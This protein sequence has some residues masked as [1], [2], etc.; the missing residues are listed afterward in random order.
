M[1]INFD[2]LRCNCGS[3]GC[4]EEYAS[5]K[6][7]NRR[8]KI[9]ATELDRLAKKGNKAAKEIWQDFGRNLGIGIANLVNILDPEIIVIGGG[10]SQ[11]GEF[12]LKPA[13]Q[14]AR[15]RIL[16]HLSRKNVKIKKSKL[17]DFA[18]AIGAGMILWT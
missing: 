3:V 4:L 18:G 6:Y 10:F 9:S 5:Q 14:E 1:A 17:G 15:K 11:A 13:R 12:I 8:T 7:I 2:G 16:S